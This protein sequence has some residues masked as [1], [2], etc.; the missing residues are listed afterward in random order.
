MAQGFYHR[1]DQLRGEVSLSLF[2]LCLLPLG[3]SPLGENASLFGDSESSIHPQFDLGEEGLNRASASAS[4]YEGLTL[5]RAGMIDD[6]LEA[7]ETAF[8]AAPSQQR[9]AHR[10]A[11]LAGQFRD[12]DRGLSILEENYRRNPSAPDAYLRLSAYLAT[13]HE[14]RNERLERSLEVLQEASDKFP[15]QPEVYQKLIEAL[16]LRQERA[17]AEAVLARAM[18]QPSEDPQY[19]VEIARIAPLLHPVPRREGNDLVNGL[20]EKAFALSGG[21]L[22]IGTRVGDFF[23][24]TEQYDK[25]RAVYEKVIAGHPEA[26][27]V[28][29]KLA[30][31]FAALEDSEM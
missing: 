22:A 10:A 25:A 7:Y 30:A 3:A 16:L 13:Y 15:N 29:E 11:D 1:I 12:I 2:V 19:W 8:R 6:A 27:E 14:N 28:R 26:L 20:Y 5:E 17:E 18:A 4:Y 9:L 23:R 31:I 24:I 21:D